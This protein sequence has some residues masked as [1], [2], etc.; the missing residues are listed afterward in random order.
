MFQ[1]SKKG[2]FVNRTVSVCETEI[3]E[4]EEHKIVDLK[5][6]KKI[7]VAIKT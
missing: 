5:V 4:V 7:E 2:T 3:D 1:E 6:V